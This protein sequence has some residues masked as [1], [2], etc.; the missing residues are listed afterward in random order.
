MYCLFCAFIA[1]MFSPVSLLCVIAIVSM[2]VYRI[3]T[4]IAYLLTYLMTKFE[5]APRHGGSN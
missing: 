5:G 3:L 2:C 1:F 4:K